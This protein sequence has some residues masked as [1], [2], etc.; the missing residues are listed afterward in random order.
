MDFKTNRGFTI[1][2]VIIVLGILS[3]LFA[4][5][6]LSI[7]NI[8]VLTTNN[9]SITVV[10]SDLK[11]QQVKAMSGD[12][13]GR[14]VPDNYGMKIL[15]DKYILFHGSSYNPSDSTNF[16]VPVDTGNQ[17]SSTFP[18]TSVVFA[19]SSGEL[20]GFVQGQDTITIS[21]INTGQSKTVRL[22]KYGT[23]TSIY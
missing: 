20:V 13:E 2:E 4:I 3:L 19:S 7:L 6:T 12:T 10:V 16:S 18:N 17:F 11:N 1:V 21:N 15:S 14:G 8:R 22:N 5:A 9:T 23:V